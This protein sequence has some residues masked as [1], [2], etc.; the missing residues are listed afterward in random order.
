M[1]N[2]VP[3]LEIKHFDSWFCQPGLLNNVVIS[4]VFEYCFW[5]SVTDKDSSADSK[6]IRSTLECMEHR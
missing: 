2:I 4:E 1:K 5:F 3:L 6:K